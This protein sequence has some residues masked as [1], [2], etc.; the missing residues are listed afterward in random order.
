MSDPDISKYQS[1]QDDTEYWGFESFSG[2]GI[3]RLKIFD[4]FTRTSIRKSKMNAVATAL[5]TIGIWNVNF[6]NKKYIIG[7]DKTTAVHKSP[8]D[9]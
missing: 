7:R 8:N 5:C 3:F 2:R 6:A 4:N 1:I 9:E